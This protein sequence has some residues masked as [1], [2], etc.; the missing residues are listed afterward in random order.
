MDTCIY[1]QCKW[2]ALSCLGHCY[3]TYHM[4]LRFL[5]VLGVGAWRLSVSLD[6]LFDV[7]GEGA[8]NGL[9]DGG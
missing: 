3:M 8:L 6:G 9:H 4:G 7:G 1:T 5:M 2:E